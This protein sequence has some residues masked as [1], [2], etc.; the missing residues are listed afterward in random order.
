M[1]AATKLGSGQ[2][3]DRLNATMPIS[4]TIPQLAPAP[5]ADHTF[6]LAASKVSADTDAV[7]LL[8]GIGHG[9]VPIENFHDFFS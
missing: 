7:D 4:R 8:P 6:G 3:A 5:G 9:S 2:Q 1:R